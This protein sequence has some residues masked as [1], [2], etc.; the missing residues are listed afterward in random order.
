MDIGFQ[1]CSVGK[2]ITQPPDSVRRDTLAACRD[3]AEV[4]T[5]HVIVQTNYAD[6]TFVVAD[7][8]FL[9]V[10]VTRFEPLDVVLPFKGGVLIS[11]VTVHLWIRSPGQN[12]FE[13]VVLERDDR[14]VGVPGRECLTSLAPFVLMFPIYRELTLRTDVHRIVSH[15]HASNTCGPRTRYFMRR[16]RQGVSMSVL[17]IVAH[18]DDEVLGVGGTLARH[19]A[20]GED[21]HVCILS[22]GVT[23]RYDDKSAAQDE[24]ERRRDRARRACEILG[25]TVSCYG[26]PDNS[27]D[28]VP[29]IDIVQTVERELYDHDPTVVYTHHYG[30]LNI[31][32]ELACRATLTAARPLPGNSVDRILAFET[33]SAS[34]WAVPE[35][36]NTF[37]PTS[38]V[39]VDEHLE[40]KEDALSVYKSE[41][42]GRP[43][44]RNIETVRENA[45]V[46]GAKAGI[47]AAEPFEVLREVRR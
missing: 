16:R 43:H 46:W 26:F 6:S 28:T 1:R 38:F 33:L 13:V 40:T 11:E 7:H 4:D 39:A 36:G 15:P 30:D 34:E 47:S 18:P 14:D 8:E 24:I 41:L 29:L 25:A 21:V 22:D 19:S 20:E 37:Q 27:F 3:I 32:H 44:P 42:R 10:H 17:C 5:Y 12:Q 2:A 9:P 23:S 31:D 35:P 45:R